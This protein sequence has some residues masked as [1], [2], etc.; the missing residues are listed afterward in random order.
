MQNLLIKT[1]DGNIIE[2][3]EIPKILP[4]IPA[5]ET[6]EEFANLCK[7]PKVW[8]NSRLTYLASADQWQGMKAF[9]SKEKIKPCNV[10][11]CVIGGLGGLN[12]IRH[13]EQTEKIVFYDVNLYGV[14][15]L[16]L[17]LQLI[18]HCSSI[19]E[20]I[21]LIYQ[22]PFDM[23]VY[24]VEEDSPWFPK[25]PES[26]TVRFGNLTDFISLP[27]E[28]KYDEILKSFLTEKAYETYRYFYI[29]CI[30]VHK[31]PRDYMCGV[32][33]SNTCHCSLLYPFWENRH[34]DNS[35]V[36]PF[37]PVMKNGNY[38]GDNINVFYVGNGWL[39][40]DSSFLDTRKKLLDTKIEVLVGSI[41]DIKPEGEHPGIY[42]SNIFSTAPG[43]DGFI[44]MIPLF[45]W[46]IGYDDN[47]GCVVKYYPK[48]EKNGI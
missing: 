37:F 11:Y 22:R 34:L 46:M 35:L 33:D 1:M 7:D 26:P 9:F 8:N 31:Y 39:E 29:P 6:W 45:D 4:E 48:G 43:A 2:M 32:S 38:M 19:N 41:L 42:M 12:F 44:G 5:W 24:K 3:P 36:C 16:D 17:Y 18:E 23:N 30:K 25:P 13:L 28:P 10:F 40:S 47:D 21:S 27:L 15:I 14:R 20:F